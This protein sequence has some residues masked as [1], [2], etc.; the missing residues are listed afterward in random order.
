[1]ITW[2]RVKNKAVICKDKMYAG[3]TDAQLLEM[4]KVIESILVGSNEYYQK[5]ARI[6]K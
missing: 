4:Q 2:R 6:I 3:Y 5:D 1:M